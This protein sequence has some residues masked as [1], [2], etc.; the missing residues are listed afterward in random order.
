MPLV[1]LALP[2]QAHALT[3]GNLENQHMDK[4]FGQYA[5]HGDCGS[6]PVITIDPSGFTFDVDG[7][8]VHPSRFEYAV[9]YLGNDYNGISM[10]F[11]PFVRSDSDFG[12]AQL[13]V[14]AD[15]VRGKLTIAVTP[16]QAATAAE[17]ALGRA[18]PYMRCGEGAKS[19]SN[20]AV[21]APPVATGQAW[22][23][24]PVA[25]QSPLAFVKVPNSPDIQSFS[26]FCNKGHPLLAMLMRQSPPL[27]RL[28]VTW[29]VAG[30]SVD[31][32]MGRGNA[33]ATFWLADLQ[34]SLLP[35]VLT[36]PSHSARLGINGRPEG[37]ASLSGSTAAIHQALG[38]CYRF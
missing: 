21:P 26:L 6:G 7:K 27:S 10:V 32:R 20:Q 14:N 37:E 38:T 24:R 33:K 11:F 2:M 9:S 3:L 8:K 19:T 16:G 30:K 18:S 31:V 13:T 25:G 5:P 34:G 1:A 15:E 17:R 29:A 22:E 35:R 4:V 12:P 23:L 36:G 28:T